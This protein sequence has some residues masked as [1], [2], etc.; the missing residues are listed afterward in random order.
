MD[1]KRAAGLCKQ[2]FVCDIGATL[3]V[4]LTAH[5]KPTP[6]VFFQQGTTSLRFPLL[7]RFSSS[8]MKAV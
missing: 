5:Q 8:V 3:M 7:V 6:D 4:V 2:D 1:V